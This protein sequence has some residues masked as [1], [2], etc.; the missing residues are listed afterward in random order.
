MFL[1]LLHLYV[2][3]VYHHFIAFKVLWVISFPLFKSQALNGDFILQG[4]TS[5]RVHTRSE[6]LQTRSQLALANESESE[7][8]ENETRRH[9]CGWKALGVIHQIPIIKETERET[10]LNVLALH[11]VYIRLSVN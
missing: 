8:E 6:I 4:G 2:L 5:G 11:S 3:M 10:R 7:W 1:H 9:N